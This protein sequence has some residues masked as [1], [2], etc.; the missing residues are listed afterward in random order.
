MNFYFSFIHLLILIT[1][2]P[3][4]LFLPP[5]PDRTL[6]PKTFYINFFFVISVHACVCVCVGGL[7]VW[8]T[9]VSLCASRVQRTPLWS[10]FLTVTLVCV[11]GS[12]SGFYNKC[13]NPMS[14]LASPA[15][16]CFSFSLARQFCKY[17]MHI[18]Y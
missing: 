12:N 18:Y 1:F 14:H 13:F 6:F 17:F 8:E 2:F 16:L 7:C 9:C 3:I 11:L 10:Q 4:T 15:L 5:S